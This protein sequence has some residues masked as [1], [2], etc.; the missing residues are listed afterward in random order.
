[1]SWYFW[2]AFD[3][4]KAGKSGRASLEVGSIILMFKEGSGGIAVS[5]TTLDAHFR[6]FFLRFFPFLNL[7]FR[8]TSQHQ[9]GIHLPASRF[10]IRGLCSFVTNSWS[11]D[12]HTTTLV[13][14]AVIED[15]PGSPSNGRPSDEVPDPDADV[16]IPVLNDRSQDDMII[17]QEKQI[18]TDIKDKLPLVSDLVSLDVLLNEYAE[19]DVIYR[20]K[21][22]VSF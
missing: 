22:Q 17:A 11:V 20:N 2:E 21:I 4:S 19:D 16:Q 1:M 14:M 5:R 13:A 12:T 15:G 7:S 3:E 18:E 9:Q 10:P 6:W 8:S